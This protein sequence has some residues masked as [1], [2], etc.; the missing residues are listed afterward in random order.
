MKES[1]HTFLEKLYSKP[2]VIIAVITVISM[3]FAFQLPRTK[4]DN[5]NFN[6]IPKDDPSRVANDEVAKIFGEETPILIGVERKYNTVFDAD[7][8]DQL[9]KIDAELLA[10]PMVKRTVSILN[11]NHMHGVDGAMV[12]SPLIDEN[13]TG[14]DAEIK[15]VKYKLRDWNEMYSRTLVSDDFKAVQFVVFLSIGSEEAGTPEVLTVCRKALDIA[16]NWDFPDSKVYVTGAPVISEMVNQATAHDLAFLVPIVICVVIGVLYLSFRRILGVVL[17]LL[18]V[19]LSVDWAV[20][21]MA[22]FG[23]KLSILSTVMPVILV[24][25]G[26][27]YGIHVVSHYFDEMGVYTRELS[28]EEYTAVIIAGMRRIMWPVFLAA[29]TTFAGFVSFCFT[30]VVP[31]AQFGIFSSFGVIAAFVIAVLLI[32]AILILAG[33]KAFVRKN[34][35][36][37]EETKLD[38]AI[39]KTLMV[40]TSHKR[41]VLFFFLLALIISAY[42]SRSIVID[43]VLVEYF[44]NDPTVADAD[45]FVREKFAGAKEISL[46]IQSDKE[47]AVV[48]PDVLLAVENFSQYFSAYPEVGKITSIAPLIKRIN[49]VLNSDA[50]PKGLQPR[51]AFAENGDESDD[52]FGELGDFSDLENDAAK[53]A[54]DD[55]GDF[56]DLLPVDDTGSNE[57]KT[58]DDAASERETAQV[59]HLK[60]LKFFDF[61]KYLD[62]AVKEAPSTE[63]LQATEL[64]QSLTEK[65]NY[66]GLAY[67]EIPHEPQKYGKTD[68]EGLQ[69]VIND[70]LILL[71]SNVDGFVDH[72]L[73]P[74]VQRVMIQ[75]RTKGQID[76]EKVVSDMQKYID[77]NFP[78]DVTVKIAGSSLIEQSLNSLVVS[79]QFI[80]LAI[81]L[82]I[83]F[84]ILSIYYRSIFAGIIGSLPLILSIL[85]NFAIMALFGIKVNIGTALVASFAIGIGIDYTIHYLDAY[86]REIITPDNPDFLYKT[87]YGSG[88]A[89]IFNAISVGAGFAVLIFSDFRILSDL[90]FLI[91][92]VM[93]VSSL[94]ALTILPV[95]L[96][97]LKPK[98]IKKVFKRDGQKAKQ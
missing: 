13:Y 84:M 22:L 34:K 2:K 66:N 49:Q 43:N 64:V 69:Q 54:D 96:N 55:W 45:N 58:I 91:C 94:S 89:I 41:T 59:E 12:A 86:H 6:F 79:S 81:S 62:E 25:V 56:G 5:N 51:D 70:Y 15:A 75:L 52:G 17:P 16:R 82:A 37:H 92:L 88:K 63:N 4:I 11:T 39:A 47:N 31:I 30:S 28:R 23:I 9:R 14:S 42:F 48:R 27:A 85:V 21:A 3:F 80:S 60:N 18:T 32:P 90:G 67:Y 78:S 97:T 95:L 71:A 57:S 26:S 36:V 83:V 61:I 44:K 24:A 74:K 8:I 76:T 10:L 20:G 77:A 33:P 68:I 38:T 73:N 19:L 65:V 72:A 53:G 98:F 40:I 29:L 87:F 50:S 46:I 7:F 35:L 1:N 93:L